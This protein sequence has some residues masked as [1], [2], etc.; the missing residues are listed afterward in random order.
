MKWIK[1]IASWTKKR[2]HPHE[3]YYPAEYQ[4]PSVPGGNEYTQLHNHM[5][6]DIGSM[7]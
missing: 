2:F 7:R 6:N 4:G 1:A 5:R 3:P